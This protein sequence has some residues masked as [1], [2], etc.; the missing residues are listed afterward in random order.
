MSKVN[1]GGWRLLI[2]IPDAT[3]K[4]GSIFV[5]ETS[6]DVY[7]MASQIGRVVALGPDAYK[8]DRFSGVPWCAEGDAVLIPKFVGTRFKIDG[9]EH[10]I[11]NDDEVL[12]VV[13][14]VEAITGV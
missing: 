2:K 12:G 7:K 4:I 13:S 6:K 14:D 11:I 9:V 1:P 5:P 3:E 8:G 10:R